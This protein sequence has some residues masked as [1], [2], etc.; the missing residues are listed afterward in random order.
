MTVH[1]YVCLAE[2]Y[3]AQE[4]VNIGEFNDSQEIY[5]ELAS[6]TFF[7][8]ELMV[9]RVFNDTLFYNDGEWIHIGRRSQA[10]TILDVKNTSVIDFWRNC[11]SARF[12]MRRIHKLLSTSAMLD[13][14]IACAVHFSPDE[15]KDKVEQKCGA[16]A[17]YFEIEQPILLAHGLPMRVLS[18]LDALARISKTSDTLEI[19]QGIDNIRL[20]IEHRLDIDNEEASKLICDFMRTKFTAPMFL[21]ALAK[22]LRE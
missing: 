6:P 15:F 5:D 17:Y 20:L 3:H 21:T 7:V 4:W 8:Q 12:F 16:I 22:A 11:E 19:I 10:A 18:V 9:A 13:L 14:L 1:L 2:K